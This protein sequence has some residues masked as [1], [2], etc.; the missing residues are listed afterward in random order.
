[1]SRMRIVAT[2]QGRIGLEDLMPEPDAARPLL[3]VI[4]GSFAPQH[5]L[6]DVRHPDCDVVLL[7]LPAFFSPPVPHYGFELFAQAFDA[8]LAAEF[9][10]RRIVVM[11]VS[12]GAA[13]ALGMTAPQIGAVVAVEP[14]L[15]TAPLWPIHRYVQRQ[16]ARL[17]P[18]QQKF[19]REAFG[20]TPDTVEDRGVPIRATAPLHVVAGDVPLSVR[21]ETY[22][23]LTSEADRATLSAHGAR[24]HIA[25]G[26]HAVTE[27]D[28]AAVTRALDAAL[29]EARWTMDAGRP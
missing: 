17:H 20:M 27:S 25:R 28:P 4:G 6:T 14:F 7:R 29:A 8:V 11:G 23:S 22:P 1:M 3:A 16:W 21:G 15:H 9:P 13:A 2:P 12:G 18:E 19:A 10:M 26:G 5:Y 24:L